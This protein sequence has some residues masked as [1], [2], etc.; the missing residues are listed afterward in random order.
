MYIMYIQSDS[1]VSASEEGCCGEEQLM[2][3]VDV[4]HDDVERRL[5]LIEQH[6]IRKYL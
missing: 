5:D 1:T 6:L 2:Q 3:Y 4:V